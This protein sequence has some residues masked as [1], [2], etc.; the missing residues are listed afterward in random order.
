MPFKVFLEPKLTINRTEQS[1]NKLLR[2]D[3]KF[4]LI[5]NHRYNIFDKASRK[6]T[7]KQETIS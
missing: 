5:P 7:P 3:H 1:I 6:A 4:R 2:R